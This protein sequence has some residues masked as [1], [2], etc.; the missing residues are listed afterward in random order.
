M[1]GY[2][3]KYGKFLYFAAKVEI[4]AGMQFKT[5]CPTIR[6]ATKYAPHCIIEIAGSGKTG[7]HKKTDFLRIFCGNF[8]EIRFRK[9]KCH[10]NL[11]I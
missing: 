3:L 4:A 2:F 8:M 5:V 6:H 1:L 10:F 7:Q 9:S 11:I